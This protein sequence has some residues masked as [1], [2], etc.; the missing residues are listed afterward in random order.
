VILDVI[1]LLVIGDVP[2][3]YDEF[4]IIDI[5]VL[6]LIQVVGQIIQQLLVKYVEID[7]KNELS[8]V[9]IVMLQTEIDVVLYV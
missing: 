7:I 6:E 9:M 3:L 1:L 5:W 2:L 8:N 4:V